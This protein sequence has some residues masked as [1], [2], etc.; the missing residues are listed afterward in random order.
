LGEDNKRI[1]KSFKINPPGTCPRPFLLPSHL[2][3]R[4]L[5]VVAGLLLCD[6]IPPN[7]TLLLEASNP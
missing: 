2:P 3:W 5:Q 7:G 6:R 4:C 1:T